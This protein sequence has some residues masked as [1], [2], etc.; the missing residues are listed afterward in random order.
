MTA[1]AQ[2]KTIRFAHPFLL[3]DA[4]RTFPAGYYEVITDEELIEGLSIP[5]Y[6]RIS[7]MILA[8]APPPRSSSVEMLVVDPREL[9]EAL[10]RDN[11][12]FQ[13]LDTEA[14]PLSPA[15]EGDDGLS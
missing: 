15:P 3:K 10:D 13:S 6:R 8:P 4:G 7:T 1:R 12:A 5:V 9:Q 2:R 11:L 14:A